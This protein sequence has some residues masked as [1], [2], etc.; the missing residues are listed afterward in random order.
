MSHLRGSMQGIHSSHRY[1]SPAIY[2]VQPS[3]SSGHLG[4]T[5]ISG[6]PGLS[7]VP[8]ERI[9]SSHHIDVI[10]PIIHF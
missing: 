2:A 5:A 10:H 9:R 7:A 1:L 6:Y 4:G 8:M 3:L